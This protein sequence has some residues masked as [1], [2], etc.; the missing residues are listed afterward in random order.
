MS[1]PFAHL[2]ADDATEF[3]PAPP[4]ASRRPRRWRFGRLTLA[5]LVLAA[6]ALAGEGLFFAWPTIQY[7]LEIREHGRE[8]RSSD[9][10]VASNAANWLIREPSVAAES[11]LIAA[12]WDDEVEVRRIAFQSLSMR[13]D[14]SNLDAA[15]EVALRGVEDDDEAVRFAALRLLGG[16]LS[17]RAEVVAFWK[18]GLSD[19]DPRI[20]R[21]SVNGLGGD[22]RNADLLQ[23]V[24][25]DPDRETRLQAASRLLAFPGPW[26]RAAVR[27][28]IDSRSNDPG[29]V[30]AILQSLDQILAAAIH[31]DDEAR[32]E[33]ADAI[34][35]ADQ[36]VVRRA[37]FSLWKFGLK[38][39][40]A[41]ETLRRLRTSEDP[42]TRWLAAI[43]LADI[44]GKGVGPQVSLVAL[45]D[46]PNFPP[47][48]RHM[49]DRFFR[50]SAERKKFWEQPVNRTWTGLVGAL[51]ALGI[52]PSLGDPLPDDPPH[53]PTV[54]IEVPCP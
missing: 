40:W 24:L 3:E 31:L 43:A 2:V 49:F 10:A 46:E 48:V 36:A 8:L 14:I 5:T 4:P 9:P 45:L 29:P 37:I 38:S 41:A 54:P 23:A 16:K 32:A 33:V 15:A 35:R 22:S 44:E 28:L 26:E 50:D 39:T 18:Q 21:A 47:P 13:R 11:E 12:A 17:S 27:V 19:P 53:A 7:R 20:R 52:D 6:L 30:P 25:R 42:V 34:I 1:D 51:D